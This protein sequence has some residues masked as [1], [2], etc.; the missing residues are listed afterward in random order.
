MIAC[1]Y[2]KGAEAQRR[3]AVANKECLKSKKQEHELLIGIL[4]DSYESFIKLT[5]MRSS[6]T[7]TLVNPVY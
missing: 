4:K 3:G 7:L 5:R 1:F 6:G 2:C